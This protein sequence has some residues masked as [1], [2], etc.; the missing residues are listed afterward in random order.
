MPSKKDIKKLIQDIQNKKA[1][2]DYD[3]GVLNT[4]K[5]LYGE[6]HPYHGRVE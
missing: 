6:P 1:L 3:L 4:L 5:W 2:T